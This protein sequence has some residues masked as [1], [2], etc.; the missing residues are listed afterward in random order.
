MSSDKVMHETRNS[1]C[2][3]AKSWAPNG[4]IGSV[5]ALHQ[6]AVEIS[7]V[8]EQT[9][10]YQHENDALT[11]L[12]YECQRVIKDRSL[13]I[14]QLNVTLN[15]VT[16]DTQWTDRATLMMETFEG[17]INAEQQLEASYLRK[18]NDNVLIINAG[19]RRIHKL[20][21]KVAQLQNILIKG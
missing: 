15:K 7:V 21:Q 16:N 20:N 12:I 14:S 2:R 9:E 19:L 6:L 17:D 10:N 18:Y 4:V 11:L 13:Q 3:H 1:K 8:Q 5:E